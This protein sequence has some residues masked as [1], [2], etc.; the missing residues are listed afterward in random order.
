ML[1]SAESDT[2]DPPKETVA[3]LAEKTLSVPVGLA[4]RQ[5]ALDSHR[6][7][8]LVAE[9]AEAAEEKH[10]LQGRPVR[11]QFELA[12]ESASEGLLPCR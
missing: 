5:I 7:A 11:P 6:R 12:T 3:E 9:L 4:F 2:V 8:S 1:A 10:G